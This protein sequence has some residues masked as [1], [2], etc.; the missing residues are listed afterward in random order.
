M[1]YKEFTMTPEEF[2][3]ANL[4]FAMGY[5]GSMPDEH[6]QEMAEAIVNRLI[7]STVARY[8]YRVVPAEKLSGRQILLDGHEFAPEGIIC[9]YLDG[10]QSACVFV[11]T[12]G[13]EFDG[14]VR[15][16]NKEGDIVADFIADSIGTV[17][18]ELAVSRLE[19]EFL[20]LE[21]HSMSYSP[22]Y[23]NWD[24]KEQ[25]L[26]FPLFP[27]KPC[28]ISLTDS[29][30]MQPEKSVSGFFAMG[31]NLVRQPYHCQ[32]CKNTKC[33]KRRHA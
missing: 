8:M 16:L 27:P 2:P 13:V 5:R 21:R 18:A 3:I 6:I 32:I 24:I 29:S 10:M 12:A 19:D 28:G 17:I 1:V 9:S 31:E 4:W 20:P 7:P 11:A 22:G 25:H 14:K 15:E 33:Y 30:L 26:F 23:C